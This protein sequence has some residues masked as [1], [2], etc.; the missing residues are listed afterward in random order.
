[1]EAISYRIPA[2][3]N[4]GRALIYFAGY[5][6]HI[7]VYPVALDDSALGARLAPYASG[8]VTL[9][10]PLDRPLPLALVAQ[11][12]RAKLRAARRPSAR[13]G[14]R[15]ART[16]RLDIAFS[17]VLQRNDSPNGWTFV[18][19]PKS[20]ECFGTRGLVK[21]DAVIDG[22]PTATAFMAMG[23]SRQMLPVK[24]AVRRAIGKE[25]GDRVRVELRSRRR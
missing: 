16:D 15:T 14:P 24:A 10:F 17:A 9:K 2:F 12:V 5:K 23:D 22:V 7:G 13:A 21:V 19:W 4:D 25:A 11:V 20:T 6:T 18:V 1:M 3:K 8:R